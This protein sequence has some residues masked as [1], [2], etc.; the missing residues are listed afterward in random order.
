MR[1]VT[2]PALCHCS[3]KL[4]LKLFCAEKVLSKMAGLFFVISITLD[5]PLPSPANTVS[6]C[7][8]TM[9]FTS[10]VVLSSEGFPGESV[11]KKPPANSGD[12][13]SIPGLGRSPGE[14]NGNPFQNSCLGNPMDRRAWW[15]VV[16]G[17]TQSDMT[18]SLTHTD[19]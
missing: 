2:V 19:T 14:G 8:L 9:L 11:I 7:C 3:V 15:A 10:Q 12:T 18:K 4:S 6:E 13:S 1:P 16:H 5:Q 17:V